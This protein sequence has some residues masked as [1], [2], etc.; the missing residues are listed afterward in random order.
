MNKNSRML[1]FLRFILILLRS[2]ERQ[3]E[4]N[5]TFLICMLFISPYLNGSVKI[6][7]SVLDKQNIAFLENRASIFHIL[8]CFHSC[9]HFET[10]LKKEFLLN[11]NTDSW[12]NRQHFSF[13]RIQ[14]RAPGPSIRMIKLTVLI[15]PF[16]LFFV[17]AVI[18]DE[19]TFLWNNIFANRRIF[20]PIGLMTFF[21]RW[22]F[23][24]R[25]N[26]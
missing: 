11:D 24:S 22:S 10:K 3:R 14:K 16:I 13:K 25:S 17:D 2:Y 20:I 8:I 5:K 6:T 4:I 19:C 21:W 23:D 12:L 15:I 1:H 7:F 18:R 26:M 9:F